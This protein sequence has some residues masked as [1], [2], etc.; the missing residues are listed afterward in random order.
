M[1]AVSLRF[2]DA[3]WF[4]NLCKEVVDDDILRFPGCLNESGTAT[5]STSEH[6]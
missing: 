6:R 4:Q 3:Q 2:P 5:T 1:L